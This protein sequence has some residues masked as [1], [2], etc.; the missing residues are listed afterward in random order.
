MS[1]KV[2]IGNR[3]YFSG[4]EK[5]L[6]EGSDSI[7]P[8]AFKYYDEKQVVAGKSMKD[9][10]RFAVAYWHT[11]CG[12]GNDPFGPGTKV[13]P[14]DA[15]DDPIQAAQDKLDAAF[16]FITKLG[17]PFYCFHDRDLA[18]EGSTVQE[19][20]RNLRLL[21]ELAGQKQ[22]ASGVCLLWG[23]ATCFRIHG[24]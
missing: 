21:V 7:N 1:D 23:T 18:P 20:E 16:E 6:Y 13:F 17:V 24:I 14:W 4:V 5:I 3:E 15:A 8:L 2:L 11:F 12:T 19:S 9:H 10:F 22:E